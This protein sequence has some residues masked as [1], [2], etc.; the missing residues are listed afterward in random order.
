MTAEPLRI[1]L[2]T[3]RGNPR[4]GG[5][6]IYVRLLGR[7]L[8][9]LGHKVDVWSGPPYPELLPGTRLVEVPSLDLWNEAALFRRPSSREL[10][11]PI[12][13][14][15]WVRTLLGEFPEPT[16]FTRRVAR[17]F[18]RGRAPHYDVVHDNQSLGAGLLEILRETP[19][20]AT[21]HHPVTVDF[22]IALAAARGVVKRWSLRRWY[23]FL[24]DQLRVAPRLDRILT[25]SEASARDLESEYS[26]PASKM[27]VVGNGIDIDLF[28]PIPAIARRDDLVVTTLSA[29]S[30]LKGFVH[31]LDA[32]AALRAKRPSLRMT[33]VGQVADDSPSGRAVDRLGLRDAIR[34]TGRVPAEEIPRIYAEATVAVVP[35]LYE[36]FGYPAG[37]AMAC[38]VPVVSTRAGALPEVVGPD[39]EAG[40]L[41]EPGDPVALARSIGALLDDRSA[42]VAMGAAGRLRVASRF[43]WRRAAERTVDAYRE[44]IAERDRALRDG[45][46]TDRRP[47][48]LEA[49]P[50]AAA[51]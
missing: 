29:D 15:E 50:R 31:L 24:R 16:T 21:I 49:E 13:R 33:V 44:A 9:E 27:R 12:H 32:F 17:D 36:G 18:A 10:R 11:D 39:G 22:R 7:A 5:Q 47:A 43:T 25:V 4:S 37:E 14:A 41:V 2:L 48:A 34:F 26:I 42:R 45:A 3:Y 23:G 20:V 46:R 19:V 30:P 40:A 38:G 51:C 28:Q 35:S 8:V 6:G 1:A